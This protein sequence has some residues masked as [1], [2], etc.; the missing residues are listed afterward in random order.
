M[1]EHGARIAIVGVGPR[2]LSVLER[3]CAGVAAAGPGRRIT[4][5]LVDPHPVGAGAVW[6][7]DQSGELLM[8]TVASQV[9]LFT[10]DSVGC[11]GPVVPGPSLYEWAR[12]LELMEDVE[13]EYDPRVLA[14]ARRLG[15]D[16]Y[17]TRAFYGAYLRW[18]HRRIARTLPDR[19]TLREHR[20]R[21]V[22]VRERADGRQV[23]SLE[24]GEEIHGLDA[25]VLTLGHLPGRPTAAERRLTA[26]ARRHGL[27]HVRPA[28]P[29]D[30]DLDTVAP[31]EPVVLRGLGLTF[32]DYLALLTTGRGGRF[33]EG[34]DGRLV[35]HPSGAEP[36]LYAG[37]RRGL[38]YHARGD[39]Q[40]GA[41]GRH[42]PRLLTPERIAALTGR[43]EPLS[44]RAD[45]WP[46]VSR[47]AEIVYYEALLRRR[48]LP[49]GPLV[50]RL[51]ALPPRQPAGEELLA[52]S[53]I[54]AADRWDWDRVLRPH[55][56]LEFADRAEFR[57]WLL[58]H[59]DRDAE[60]AAAGNVDGPVKAA[61]DA[62]RDLRNEIRQLVDH[63]GITGS[64]YE[65]ELSGWYTPLNAFV[66]IGP[67]RRRIEEMA[68]LIRAG[69]LEPIGPGLTVTTAPVPCAPGAAGAAEPAFLA[70]SA[71]VPGAPVRARVLIEARL[72]EP[73]LRSAA[74]PLLRGLLAT[75]RAATYRVPDPDGGSYDTGALAVTGRPARVVDAQGRPQERLFAFG[76]PCEGVH[77][78]TAA[79]IRPGVGSV[80]LQDADAIAQ[81]ALRL[82][83]HDDRKPLREL[84]LIH[85]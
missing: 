56:G 42:L 35:Y 53:G 4:V 37:S 50:A 8:N 61:L 22:A 25:V 57:G 77:W 3:L 20:A 73:G 39:N 40:K 2:G 80:T 70:S 21:A 83:A 14:E 7:T 62:L 72:P 9:T 64:S 75:G 15:P 10:D 71:V 41:T 85:L 11:A 48:G 49:S 5:H 51:L 6:R 16:D 68:A 84:S 81:A 60:Q 18:V 52:E 82:A 29:A 78:V 26:Y 44:F 45:I 32:F 43:P 79:G 13:D 69:V 66:S 17:P 59:L 36:R 74:D 30:V 54:A 31:G 65:K 28:N 46:L 1:T 58:S 19:V 12:F 63:A 27:R 38:P 76:V 47:E 34:P 67:P 23:L 33:T 24:T 55:H